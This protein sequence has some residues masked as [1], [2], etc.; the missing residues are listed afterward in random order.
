MDYVS[1]KKQDVSDKKQRASNKK[2]DA[3]TTAHVKG[4]T[5]YI[6][7]LNICT[8]SSATERRSF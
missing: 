3:C 2:Q 6:T 1:D 4:D 7:Q 8:Y 5:I